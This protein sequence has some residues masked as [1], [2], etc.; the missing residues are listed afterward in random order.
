MNATHLSEIESKVLEA[1]KAKLVSAWDAA[2]KKAAD[3]HIPQNLNTLYLILMSGL[4]GTRRHQAADD[5]SKKIGA[6]IVSAD[7]ARILLREAGA[8]YSHIREIVY[9]TV[10]EF[11]GKNISVII[12]SDHASIEKVEEGKKLGAE[13]NAICKCIRTVA[14]GDAIIANLLNDSNLEQTDNFFGGAATG[15]DFVSTV[16]PDFKG[17]AIALREMWRRTP[18]HFDWIPGAG[19][20]KLK[21]LDFVDIEIDTTKGVDVSS[22]EL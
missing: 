17:R 10:R 18:H 4:I 22:V 9:G 20:W 13:F 16:A 2:N 19:E 21:K 5:I 12:D 15:S 11:L 6:V 1:Y 8:D 14:T 3:E 7:D